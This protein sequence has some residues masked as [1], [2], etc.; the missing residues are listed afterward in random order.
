[1]RRLLTICLLAL[2]ASAMIV[3]MPAASSA[4]ANEASKPSITRVL[5]MRVSVG[6]TITITGRNFE[7]SRLANTVIFRAPDGRW[8]FARPH[9]VGRGQLRVVVPDAVSRLLG[10]TLSKPKPT[11]LKLRVL[12]GEFSSFTPRRLSPVVTRY[13]SD[14][15]SP[16][17]PNPSA[18]DPDDRP[19][20]PEG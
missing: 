1:M 15:V 16:V 2:S 11:R 6:G 10:G 17:G 7:S 3:G 13:D 4:G 19:A 8:A 18:G 12:A 9:R 20:T 14:Q 5:P